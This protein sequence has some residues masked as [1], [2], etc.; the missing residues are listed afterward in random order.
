MS[1]SSTEQK[2]PEV[3]DAQKAEKQVPVEAVGKA[4]ADKRAAQAEAAAA[5][6]ELA[7]IKEQADPDGLLAAFNDA[8]AALQEQAKAEVAKELAP[9][10]AEV[11]KWKAAVAL[12]LNE[13]QAEAVMAVRDK[14]PGMPE[15]QALMIARAEKPDLFPMVSPPPF[16]P[17]VNGGIPTGGDSPYRSAPQQEDYMAKISEAKKAGDQPKATHYAEQEFFRRINKLRPQVR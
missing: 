15:Q 4:R 10:R 12:G 7:E 5:K 13:P 1:E 16:N 14:Y 6:K 9:V 17:S 8:K 3:Q 11:A 2:Q